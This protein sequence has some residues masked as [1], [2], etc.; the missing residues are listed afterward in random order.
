MRQAGQGITLIVGGMVGIL[1]VIG[2]FEEGEYLIALMI[3]CATIAAFTLGVWLLR[4]A[5]RDVDS[6]NSN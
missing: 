1:G 2:Q 4:K 6:D 3:F 5:K